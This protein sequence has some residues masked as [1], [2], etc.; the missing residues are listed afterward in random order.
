LEVQGRLNGA[1]EGSARQAVGWADLARPGVGAATSFHAR[2][3][4]AGPASLPTCFTRDVTPLG[5]TRDI[6]G[7][8][9][10]VL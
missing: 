1:I 5:F 8:N 10:R 9:E 4:S 3:P 6:H 2:Q 7:T